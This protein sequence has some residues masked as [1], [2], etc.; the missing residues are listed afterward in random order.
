MT[1]RLH[2]RAGLAILTLLAVC[3]AASADGVLI[4]P[5]RP[6]MPKAT[7]LPVKYHRVSVTIKDQVATTKIDQ[8]FTNP[9]GGQLEAEYIFPLPEEAAISRFVMFMDGKPVAGALLDKDEARRT[10]EDIVRKMRDPA[11][12]EYVGRNMFKARVFPVPAK[13]ETRIQIEYSEVVPFDNHT[14]KYTYPLNTEKFSPTPLAEV[15]VAAT[16]ESRVAIK[17][18]YSPTHKVDETREGDHKVTVGFEEKEVKPDKDFV[19]YYT[20]ADEDFGLGLVTHKEQGEDGHFLLLLAPEEEVQQKEIEAKDVVF[21]FDKSGSMAGQKIEQ[22][23][24]ALKFCLGNL[25]EQ[26]RFNLITFS[27]GVDMLSTKLLAAAEA[28][29]KKAQEFVDE[30]KAV[31]GTNINEALTQALKMIEGGARPSMVVFLTDGL[32]TVGVVD[33]DEIVKNVDKLNAVGAMA[34]ARIYRA[35]YTPLSERAAVHLVADEGGATRRARIFTF[36][37][38]DDVN[39]H[40]LDK[41]SGHNG[42]ATTYVRPGEDIEV[43]VSGLYEKLAYPVL[44]KVAVDFG[45]IY[46]YDYYPQELPDLFKGSQ[47]AVFGRYRGHGHLAVKLA[48]LVSGKEKGWAFD[49][50]FP[51]EEAGNDFIPRLWATRRIG[52]LLD[53]IRLKGENKE[54]KE[55]IVHLSTTYGIM[56]PY[57]SYLVTEDKEAAGRAAPVLSLGGA[58]RDR[59]AQP[60]TVP[61]APGYPPGGG[62]A[63]ARGPQGEAGPAYGYGGV[64]GGGQYRD[65]G[66][67]TGRGAINGSLAIDGLKGEATSVETAPAVI[68]HVGTETFYFDGHVWLHSNYQEG[69]TTYKIKAYSKAYFDLL[70]ARPE[71]G[72]YFALGEEVALVTGGKCVR[73]GAEG[74]ETL[75]AEQLKEIAALGKKT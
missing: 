38:G 70:A 22:A 25:N 28:K 1:R 21:V 12:L 55:E 74:L 23:K 44:S 75:S 46:V 19:L 4:V 16:V 45:D 62:Y 2:V 18:V 51:E 7:P 63:G 50:D 42:G 31:G 73:V 53:E 68:R 35:L 14:C 6:D 71:W 36:G 52:Y 60:T 8:A 34:E 9:Y 32:P 11:L 20:L 41:V 48:G 17:S 27:T 37:V 24:Q 43:K 47:L 61:Y 59:L 39:T 58:V 56:T 72:K 69:L 10:Y 29:S 15:S 66:A 64:G 67:R 5:P 57:T 33:E 40:L 30:M 49:A 26:D 3:A 54:L 13:G 65:L